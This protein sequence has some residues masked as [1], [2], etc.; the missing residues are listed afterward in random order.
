MVLATAISPVE[1]TTTPVGDPTGALFSRTP[2]EE[3]YLQ[4]VG[5]AVC[6][7][8]ATSCESTAKSSAKTISGADFLRVR[9]GSGGEILGIFRSLRIEDENGVRGKNEV[10]AIGTG[11]MAR[12]L[13]ASGKSFLRASS[14]G[15]VWACAVTAQSASAAATKMA[16]RVGMDYQLSTL[17]AD[18]KFLRWGCPSMF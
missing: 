15:S 8:S 4:R 2:L 3:K 14:C 5:A 1:K 7:V 17:L 10:I 13:V 18:E 16:G 11:F 12:T 9:A 6:D